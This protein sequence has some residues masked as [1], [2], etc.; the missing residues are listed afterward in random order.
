MNFDWSSLPRDAE[1]AANFTR[2]LEYVLIDLDGPQLVVAKDA[3]GRRYLGL[4]AD[5]DERAARWIYAPTTDLELEALCTGAVSMYNAIAKGAV[6]VVD[7]VDG[8]PRFVTRASSAV[9][10]DDVLPVLDANLPEDIGRRAMRVFLGRSQR[11]F[12]RPVLRCG[13]EPV[14]GSSISFAALAK[15]AG[16]IQALWSAIASASLPSPRTTEELD[17][18]AD[19][20]TLRM[21]D[22]EA[23]SFGIAMTDVVDD[24]FNTIASVYVDLTRMSPGSIDRLVPFD[25]G[26]LKQHRAYLRVLHDHRAEVLAEFGGGSA[27]VGSGYAARIADMIV[28][29]RNQSPSADNDRSVVA[30]GYFFGGDLRRHTFRFFDTITGRDLTGRMPAR[31][32][33]TISAR[34][35]GELGLGERTLYDVEIAV[36]SDGTMIMVDAAETQA[37]LDF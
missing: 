30:R 32:Q 6:D 35:G 28:P 1:Y 36:R 8:S 23:A 4:A 24:A 29:G 2:T 17:R 33:Q 14:R 13:G 11:T 25:A 37:R 21:A 12:V 16:S 15:I 20:T 34:H 10:P 7:L 3:S 19:V 27:Y 18:R 5:E 22:R 26:V 9:I 31:L